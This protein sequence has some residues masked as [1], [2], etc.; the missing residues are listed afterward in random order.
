MDYYFEKQV[1]YPMEETIEKI[2]DFLKTHGFGIL[3]QIDVQKTLKDKVGA[4][5]KPYRILGAC[6]PYFAHEA[7]GKESNVGLML[8][9]NI[10]VREDSDGQ[11]YVAAVNPERTIKTI[12][13]DELS[14][15]AT[16]VRDVM[17]ALIAS[18]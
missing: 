1:N 14:F 18:I 17:E 6:N 15:L 9:C 10:V 13:N 12:G 4:E 16:R 7:I 5:I 11:T 2:G 8:P 3:T